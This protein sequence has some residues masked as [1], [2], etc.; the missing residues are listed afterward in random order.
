MAPE[1]TSQLLEAAKEVLRLRSATLGERMGAPK[2]DDGSRTYELR[3]P[4]GST[5][6]IVEWSNPTAPQGA[7]LTAERAQAARAALGPQ[8][9]EP[10]VVPRLLG[11]FDGRS[12]NLSPF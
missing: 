10:V 8:L 3:T 6:A 12:A 11:T 5:V 2:G 1:R 7:A 9:G 4:E